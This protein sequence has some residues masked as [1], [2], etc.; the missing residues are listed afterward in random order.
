MRLYVAMAVM[1]TAAVSGAQVVVPNGFGNTPA[2]G[3]FSLTATAAA[4]RTYQ[5]MIHQ[6]QLTSV[7]GQQLNGLKFRLNESVTANWPSVATSFSFFDIYIG[8]G[9]DPAART[10]SFL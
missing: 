2:N 9:V 1:A 3:V 5:F 7:V 10:T 4:G 8:P 6:N